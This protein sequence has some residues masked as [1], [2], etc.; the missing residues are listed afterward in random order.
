LGNPF[1]PFFQKV[2]GYSGLRGDIM[3]LLSEESIRDSFGLKNSFVDFFRLPWN[4]TMFSRRFGGEQLGPLF[5][6]IMP[7][8][9]LTGFPGKILRRI[10]LFCLVYIIIWFF[11]YQNLRFVLPVTPF[12]SI[13][14]SW[15]IIKITEKHNIISRFI[16]IVTGVYLALL[17]ALFLYYVLPGARVVVGLESSQA[18]LEHNERSFIVSDYVNKYLPKGSK[19]L[20]LNEG[21]TFFIDLPNKRELYYWIYTAYDN[22]FASSEKV[23][24]YFKS[25]GFT[26]ILCAQGSSFD[27][28]GGPTRL[29]RLFEDSVFKES[30]LKLLTTVT[31]DAKNA[32][33]VKYLI[34]QIK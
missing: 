28:R 11:Q 16:W 20:V 3:V 2:F 19:V 32:F 13:I 17:L 15:I 30:Y 23:V 33:G 12:L 18:Y 10:S 4:I 6:A 14:A 27:G 34:Y 29:T 5:L 21:H 26:H 24:S 22:K 1:F 25:Q 31:T 9:F 8:I 7:A